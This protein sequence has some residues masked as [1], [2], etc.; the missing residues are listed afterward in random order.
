MYLDVAV[1]AF[2]EYLAMNPV[3]FSAAGRRARVRA[4]STSFYLETFG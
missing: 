4:M 3:V 1:N 2:R